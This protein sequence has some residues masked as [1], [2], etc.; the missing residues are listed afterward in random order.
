MDK[1]PNIAITESPTGGEFADKII[2]TS[3]QTICANKKI[4]GAYYGQDINFVDVTNLIGNKIARHEISIPVTNH[5]MGGD[6]CDGIVKSLII[7][8]DD[9]TK[10]I[11]PE[12]GSVMYGIN[13]I[14]R[15]QIVGATC[16]KQDI[17]S[18]VRSSYA[19]GTVAANKLIESAG[20]EVGPQANDIILVYGDG[21][22]YL[23]PVGCEIKF[24]DMD[25]FVSSRFT[26][27]RHVT[28]SSQLCMDE[29]DIVRTINTDKICMP[30]NY[31]FNN[32][33]DIS[34]IVNGKFIL[35]IAYSVFQEELY[36]FWVPLFRASER[37]LILLRSGEI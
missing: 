20:I 8:Y 4:I 31:K 18:A 36:F 3:S 15:Q 22:K 10:C 5:A 11:V 35:V 1:I 25:T 12:N 2:T 34:H 14:I 26:I 21:T 23:F 32:I 24:I 33:N 28:K 9:H 29:M 19:N 37:G 16:G 27:K 17:L 7:I 30:N 6:P 13:G